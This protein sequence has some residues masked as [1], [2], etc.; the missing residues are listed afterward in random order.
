MSSGDESDAESMSTDM[1]EDICDGSQSHPL[2]N[3]REERYKICDWIKQ[4]QAEWKGV[5]LST[6]K[7]GKGLHK[8]SKAA[9][10]NIYQYLPILGESWSEVSYFI[11]EPKK[12]Q[13][14]PDYRLT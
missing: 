6:Q 14:W 2:I 13:K 12:L 9:V 10:N 1:L 4:G 3:R 8:V 11:P 5:L 7:M